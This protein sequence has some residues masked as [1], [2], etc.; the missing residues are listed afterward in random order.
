VAVFDAGKIAAQ[1]SR[2]PL[3]ISLRKTSLTAITANYFTNID[4]RLLFWHSFDALPDWRL[5]YA[6]ARRGARGFLLE[7]SSGVPRH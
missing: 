2:A 7:F 3:D 6:E 1:Q 5:Y 4:L